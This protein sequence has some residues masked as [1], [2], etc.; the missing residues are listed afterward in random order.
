MQPS[1]APTEKAATDPRIAFVRSYKC[2][3][4][5]KLHVIFC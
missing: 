5:P 4:T 3:C 2:Y 1:Q